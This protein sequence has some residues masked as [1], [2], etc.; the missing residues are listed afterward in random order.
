MALLNYGTLVTAVLLFLAAIVLLIAGRRTFPP[1]AKRALIVLL[2]VLTLYFAFVLWVVI[3][4]G[5][6]HPAADPVP[7]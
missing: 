2:C 1:A 5:T 3:A 7:R 6:V 4:S